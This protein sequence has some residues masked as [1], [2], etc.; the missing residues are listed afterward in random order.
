M[1]LLRI[2]LAVALLALTP[3]AWAQLPPTNNAAFAPL[4]LPAP[5]AY[6]AADGRPGPAYW[7]NRADYEIA[8]TL[9]T[10]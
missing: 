1:R 10:T 8:V 2:A 3:A 6:R 4:D 9:D 5:N 7:Q